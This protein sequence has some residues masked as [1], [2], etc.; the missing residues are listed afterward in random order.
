ME[1]AVPFLVFSIALA[2]GAAISDF[3]FL[4]IPNAISAGIVLSFV[5][6]AALTAMPLSSFLAHFAVGA[7]VLTA[8]IGLFALRAL[9]GGDG[10]LLAALSVWAGPE[11]VLPF[12]MYT[13][14]I[15]GAFGFA[16]LSLERLPLPARAYS[17]EWIAA[18]GKRRKFPYGVAIALGAVATFWSSII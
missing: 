8:G 16:I 7:A 14:L 3:R 9:G 17:I 5:A 1:P 2:I 11:L 4:R 13:V 10:K 18:T 6:A 15:G 12:L